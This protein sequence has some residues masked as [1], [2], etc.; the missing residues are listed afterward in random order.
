MNEGSQMLFDNLYGRL[1]DALDIL[2]IIDDPFFNIGLT[3]D[4]T[5]IIL[6]AL[7]YFRNN[8]IEL[9]SYSDKINDRK[10]QIKSYNDIK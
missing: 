1:T 3:K 9:T 4:E 7:K 2:R 6:C 10:N 8:E 5:Y